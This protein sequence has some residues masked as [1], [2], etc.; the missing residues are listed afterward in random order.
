MAELTFDL[1]EIKSLMEKMQQTNLGKLKIKVGDME[2]KIE[3]KDPAPV[4]MT[5]APMAAPIPYSNSSETIITVES[6]DCVS[7]P[8]EVDGNIVKSPIV[9]TFYSAAAPDK[10]AFVEVGSKVKK[11]DVLFVIESMKLMNE[12]QSEFD[13]EVVEIKVKN[14]QGVEYNQPIMVIK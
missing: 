12:I 3:A 8:V 14:S 7:K 4:T 2:L 13:G 6:S 5:Q 1:D 9:G 11:G 10:P